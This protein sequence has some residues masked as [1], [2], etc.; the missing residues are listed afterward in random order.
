MSVFTRLLAVSDDSNRGKL[1]L[2]KA[3][4][5]ANASHAELTLLRVKTPKYQGIGQWLQQKVHPQPLV[6]HLREKRPHYPS[7][8]L[9]LCLKQCQAKDLPTAILTELKQ[10]HY[11]L[12]LVEHH[13][14]SALQCELGHTDDWQLLQRVSLPVMFVSDSPW[15]QQ[16]S[17]LAALELDEDTED[18]SHFNHRLLQQAFDFAGLLQQRLHLLNC[19]QEA[20][21]SMAFDN[22]QPGCRSQKDNQWQKLRQVARPLALSD[23]LLHLASGMP[24]HVV[25]EAAHKWHSNIVIMGA[26]E[27]R[28]LLSELNGHA[29]EQMLNQLQCDVLALKPSCPLLH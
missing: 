9:N 4:Q 27:H 2:R 20:D 28:G 19:Y 3:V 26:A 1:A 7:R 14:Y 6:S 5:L 15:E 23:E 29:S 10:A 24:D 25:P 17:L 22:Q 8:E 18:H 13:S 12:L 21:I 16:G 11:D